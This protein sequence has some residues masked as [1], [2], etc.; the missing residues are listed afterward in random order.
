MSLQ[1][2]LQ[3]VIGGIYLQLVEG[4]SHTQDS[5][6]L[7]C[8]MLIYLTVIDLNRTSSY[9][10]KYIFHYAVILPTS[11]SQPELYWGGSEGE[12]RGGKLLLESRKPQ[13]KLWA[14]GWLQKG[15]LD[16]LQYWMPLYSDLH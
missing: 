14:A 10:Q 11:S 5:M 16:L 3:Q 9:L 2:G 15:V 8:V 13:L 4:M 7:S 6:R 1:R 12:D